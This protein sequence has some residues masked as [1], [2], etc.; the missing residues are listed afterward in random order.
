MN[1][2][3]ELRIYDINKEEIIKK[4]EKFGGKFINNYNQ[5]RYIYDF[6]PVAKNKWIRLRTDGHKT[7]LTIKECTN[8]SISG[9][10]ELEIEVSDMEKTHLI[11][12]E[13]GYK[14]R[15]IQE[16]K[17]T[18]YILD[19]VEIDIDSWPYLK[20]FVEFESD[21]EEKIY[22]VL[23]K[24]DYK[25]SDTTTKIAQDFYYDINFTDEDMNNLSFKE[26]K[27]V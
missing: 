19:G 2:E 13:L 22:K 24:L 11:L 5:K 3:I 20:D 17:R 7:T 25:I 12:Q 6:N 27:H 1:T 16:N 8:D 18:R 4:I 9:T 10:K 26:E 15:S 14:R 21:N 23:E